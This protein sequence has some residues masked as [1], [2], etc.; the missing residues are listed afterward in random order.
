[1][2]S[3]SGHPAD[4]LERSMVM[5]VPYSLLLGSRDRPCPLAPMMLPQILSYC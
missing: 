3:V 5:R 4:D 2:S 1:M